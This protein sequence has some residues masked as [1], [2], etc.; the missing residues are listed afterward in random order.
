MNAS[1]TNAGGWA[2]AEL[3]KFLNSRLYN[4]LPTQIKLLTKQVTVPSSI[5]QGYYEISTSECYITIPAAVE[6]VNNS[7]FNSSPYV[8]EMAVASGKTISYLTSNAERVR[9][10]VVD[11]VAQNYWT[12]SP[13][14][15]YS[16]Y[17][18][19]VDSG[20]NIGYYY[21]G[22]PTSSYGVVI[23]ISF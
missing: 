3:N 14:T 18:V 7:T 19:Y 1:S 23:E 2:E 5:G 20:G 22:Y 8:N 10:N 15:Y 9:R 11:G 17:F 21:Y 13:S 16:N 6:L 4:A 12:R